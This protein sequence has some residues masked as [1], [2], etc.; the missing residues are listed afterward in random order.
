MAE[1]KKISGLTPMGTKTLSEVAGFAGYIA[2]EDGTPAYNIK[3]T[4]LEIIDGIFK[5]QSAVEEGVAQSKV[6]AQS[7]GSI[8]FSV[9]GS[10]NYKWELTS[11]GHFIPNV[12]AAYDLGNAE[13]K[14]R[15]LFLSDN[16]I[17][18]GNP[19]NTTNAQ[20][21][22]I[23]LKNE[24]DKPL[25]FF[26]REGEGALQNFEGSIMTNLSSEMA[27]A[28]FSDGTLTLPAFP[29]IP[30]PIEYTGEDPIKVEGTTISYIGEVFTSEQ[31][32]EIT[33]N[34]AKV[35]ITPEQAAEITANTAKVGITPEQAEEITANT[36]KVG[37][38][39]EQ[40]EEITANTAKVGI[41][42]EQAEEITANTAKVS[43]NNGIL[44]INVN[45]SEAGTFG[46]NASEPTTINIAASGG[47]EIDYTGF[48]VEDNK[49]TL[50]DPT[51]PIYGH[52]EKYTANG[53]ILNGQPV[54]YSYSSNLVRAISPGAL[55]NQ[56]ELIG[57]ALNDANDGDPVNVL[58]E[59]LCT[60]RRLTILEPAEPGDDVDHP[61]GEGF[62]SVNLSTVENG[63]Y[64]D[65][66]GNYSDSATSTVEWTIDGE[67]DDRFMSLDFSDSEIWEFEGTD[68]RIYDRLFFE[69]SYDGDE[70][71]QFN[72]DWGLK[73]RNNLPGV[74][75][76]DPLFNNGDWD[77]VNDDGEY[78]NAGGCTLPRLKEW[79]ETYKG[80][81]NLI[82]NFVSS[83][84]DPVFGPAGTPY[85]RVRANF[86]SDSSE[87][88]SGWTSIMK[89]TPTYS[90]DQPPISVPI[91]AAVNLSAANLT[92]SA[93]ATEA[94]SSTVKIGRAISTDGTNNALMIRVIH[95][96]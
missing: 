70:Y 46:A 34:T 48:N 77:D 19:D 40:S 42:P 36:A 41:T 57:I 90:G 67:D 14:V 32:A 87:V 15:H 45:G 35:G 75:S 74:G 71:F 58:T 37:I 4:G 91:N 95:N 76:N 44:T 93:L 6:E 28:D 89:A 8:E 3:C 65:G 5:I 18:M 78:V 85:K 7:E 16:S 52:A 27:G 80:D 64:F 9:G 26:S 47:G 43:A 23:S 55:P 11:G 33:A 30:E 62:T 20:L 13:F 10:N 59:G 94:G 72:W 12:N 56:I 22:K 31:A 66:S 68:S 83:V 50:S 38:T 54:V 25:L 73:V 17:Y 51:Q 86:I 81:T 49:A 82:I 1:N 84:D 53:S 39:P 92:R 24:D 29:D 21:A 88:R 2:A 60:A 61:M 96:H 79:A 63:T 69:V